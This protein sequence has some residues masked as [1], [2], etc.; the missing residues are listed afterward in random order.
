MK[1]EETRMF[2]SLHSSFFIRTSSFSLLDLPECRKDD[3]IVIRPLAVEVAREL[4][5]LDEAMAAEDVLR[6]LVV[7]EDI[8]AE[9]DEVH[10]V[11]CEALQRADGVGAEAAVPGGRLADEETEP[12]CTRDPVDVV[13]R[14]VADVGAVVLP[15]DREMPLV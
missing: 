15:L 4:P 9:L 6:F 7:V 11:E 5:L 2:R 3:N 14:S 8:D 1:N 12:R 10:L 13:D